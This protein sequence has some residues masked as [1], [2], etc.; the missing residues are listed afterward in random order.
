MLIAG[1]DPAMNTLLARYREQQ[2]NITYLEPVQLA[3][4]QG[5]ALRARNPEKEKRTC[6]SATVLTTDRARS[7]RLSLGTSKAPKREEEQ[8]KS[9]HHVGLSISTTALPSTP[10]TSNI[11]GETP[12]KPVVLYA[13]TR[14]EAP[15]LPYVT[16]TTLTSRPG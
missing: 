6:D 4:S 14:T 12:V 5:D 2:P 7:F 16:G 8:V 15:R 1:L 3:R 9:L 13:G 11:L 10:R